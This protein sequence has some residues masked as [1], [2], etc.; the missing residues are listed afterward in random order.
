MKQQK[1]TTDWTGYYQ[2]KRSIWSVIT[3]TVTWRI[4]LSLVK[5]Y[6][7]KKKNYV[8]ELGGGNSDFAKKF[9]QAKLV[10]KYVI[11]D[12]NQLACDLAKVKLNSYPNLLVYKK[13]LI[14][15]REEG[16]GIT[17]GDIVYSTGLIEHFSKEN[18]RKI[19]QRHFEWC[20]KGGIVLITFPTP[21]LQ[22]KIFRKTMEWIGVWQFWDEKPLYADEIMDV[23]KENGIIL[24]IYVNYWLP[25]TQT[26]VVV[27][28]I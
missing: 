22:Y 21:T 15:E 3:Q 25:L 7:T 26:V 20:K 9:Y 18:R 12:N 1:T 28:N 14:E 8:V 27:R 2:K 11:V 23:L 19:I 24:K 16:I 13:D 10:K 17:K 6:N 5:K 4:L